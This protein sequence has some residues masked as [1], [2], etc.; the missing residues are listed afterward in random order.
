MPEQTPARSWRSGSAPRTARRRSPARRLFGAPRRRRRAGIAGGGERRRSAAREVQYVQHLG[1][2]AGAAQR[3]DAVVVAAGGQ[4]GGGERVGLAGAAGFTQARVGLGHE[5]GGAA[6]EDGT[7]SPGSGRP[8]TVGASSA[9]RCQLRG[10]SASS[11]VTKEGMGLRSSGVRVYRSRGMSASRYVGFEVCRLRGTSLPRYLG[12][13]VYR[14]EVRRLRSG[15]CVL[16]PSARRRSSSPRTAAARR[17]R[18]GSAAAVAT[19]LPAI[20]RL[21]S[22]RCAPWKFAMP[23]LEGELAWSLL[24]AIS[25][26]TRSFQE[27]SRVKIAS[28]ASAG[29]ARG[30]T[31]RKNTCRRVQPSISARLL[32]L[33]GQ[34]EEELP[35]QEDAERGR[36]PRHDRGAQGVDE[37]ERGEQEVGGDHQQLRRDHDRGDDGQERR[38][39][40]RGTSAARSRSRPSEHSTR[41]L[42]IAVAETIAV[43]PSQQQRPARRGTAARSRR[44]CSADGMNGGGKLVDVGRW[45]ST[46]RAPSAR[47]AAGTRWRSAA[48]A[49]PADRCRVAGAARGVPR[50]S[51]CGTSSERLESCVRRA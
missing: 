19:T 9:A 47:A 2:G 1:G 24:I 23:E 32:Q 4:L 39:P 12:A 38:R 41:W 27:L 51:I 49:V 15:A 26:Q 25:G 35:H 7:R 29:R 48:A 45:T 43:L 37:A 36:Q 44:W 21:H 50:H 17:G 31:M 33:R 6:A 28:V 8:A 46:R 10:W 40:A 5:P 11:A 13:E 3:Q 18:T 20:S 14:F 16:S 34:R 22:V 42:T 30:S